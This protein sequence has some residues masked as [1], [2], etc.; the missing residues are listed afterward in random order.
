MDVMLFATENIY[1]STG[2]SSPHVADE[3]FTIRLRRE[4]SERIHRMTTSD[5]ISRMTTSDRISRMTTS[6]RISRTTTMMKD[7]SGRDEECES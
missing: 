6:D 5:R 3:G 7:S 2:T 4:T 1:K